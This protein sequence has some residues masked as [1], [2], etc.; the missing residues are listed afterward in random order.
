MPFSRRPTS[1]GP[2]K[3]QTLTSWPW[4]DLDLVYNLDLINSLS[5]AKLKLQ[6]S[7]RISLFHCVTLTQSPYYWQDLDLIWSRCT[8]VPKMKFLVPML[9]IL[10][11][12]LID[13]H[14]D[15]QTLWKNRHTHP[16]ILW[17]ITYPHT[18]EV[19]KWNSP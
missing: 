4:N 17:K 13:R 3:R 8:T 2:I 15:P 5:I 1:H 18:R 12:E 6:S 14:T 11:P 16:Q 10:Q 9:Q 7:G 19:I